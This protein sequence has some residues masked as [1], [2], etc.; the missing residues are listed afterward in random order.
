MHTS[1]FGLASQVRVS[2]K[3]YEPHFDRRAARWIPVRV[4]DILWLSAEVRM[5]DYGFAY[6]GFKLACDPMP[7]ADGRF[8]AQ[9]VIYEDTGSEMLTHRH[10]SLG[11]FE[12]EE[13]AVGCAYAFAKNWVDQKID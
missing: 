9:V 10:S 4:C 2:V 5:A 8:G 11:Y 12:K 13:D 7:M 1:S 3:R 6:K